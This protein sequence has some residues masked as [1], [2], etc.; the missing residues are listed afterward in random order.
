MNVRWVGRVFVFAVLLP[1]ASLAE[2][3]PAYLDSTK[4]IETRVEDLLGRMTLE[5]KVSLVHADSKFSTAAI[6]R[7]GIPRRWMSDGP[8]GVREE[9]GPD[10]WNAAGR[11]DDFVTAMPA[12]ICL[13]AT[14]NVDL[15]KLQGQTIGEEARVRGKDIMLG[16]AVNIQRTPLCGRNFEY[17]GEDPWLTSR[18]AVNYIEGEQSRDVASCVKH[19]ALNNQEQDR[20]SI[21]VKVDERAL[22]EIY[23]PAF[24]AAVKEAD[25]LTVMGAYNQF[26]GQHCCE[27]D[28]LLNKILKGEWKFTGLVMS[29]WGGVH[30]TK[31]AAINGLDL[32]MGTNKPY[33]QFYLANAFIDGLKSGEYPMSVLDDKVR[34]NLRV[35]FATKVLDK[36]RAQGSLNT[37]QHQETARKVAEE[38]IVLLKNEKQTLPLDVKK[39]R[40]IAVIGDNATRLQAAGGQSSGLKAFYEVSPLDGVVRR[41]GRDVNVIFSQ[42]YVVPPSRR[43]NS[44]QPVPASGPSAEE[45]RDRAVAAAKSADVAIYIGGLNKEPFCDTEGTDRKDMKLPYGQDDLIRAVVAANPHTVVVLVSGSAVEMDSWLDQVPAV[46]EAWYGGSEAGNALARVLFGDVNPSGKLPF[47]FPRHLEDSPAHALH[48]YPGENGVVEYKEGLLVGYRWFDTKQIEPLFCFGHGLSYTNFEYSNLKLIPGKDDNA[49]T[50]QF[51]LQNTGDRDGSE[52]AQIYIHDVQP[53]LEQP[54]KQLKGFQ[55]LF[56]KSGEKQSVT[57]SLPRHAFEFYDP[58]KSAWTTD[59]GDYEIL[60]GASSRDIRLHDHTRL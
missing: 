9:I 26:R 56:L 29:D 52:T 20:G 19:F 35:M 40:S 60:V 2:D 38:G 27:N 25:V 13:A 28:V 58:Q 37:H 53:R 22:R 39:I 42:G 30:D 6:P 54:D 5:E 7:L 21:D 33:D 14:W 24:E 15:A 48:A 3:P 1:F 59:P 45:L 10:T 43:R 32:E 12:S 50:V 17:M 11:T 34:R 49:V 47:T 36:D 23:L 46:V 8:M 41:A 4:P 51:D 57:V 31:E 55:K 44:T 16:P 18:I